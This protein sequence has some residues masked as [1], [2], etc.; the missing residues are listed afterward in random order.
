LNGG[1][2]SAFWH[3]GANATANA[4][5]SGTVI[6]D[7]LIGGI[8]DWAGVENPLA[9]NVAS[10]TFAL[11]ADVAATAAVEGTVDG[12]TFAL[13]QAILNWRGIPINFL[14]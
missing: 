12:S 14:Y 5:A 10:A 11:N 13:E 7:T 4:G 1:T 2:N 6:S 3:G 8:M 9:W